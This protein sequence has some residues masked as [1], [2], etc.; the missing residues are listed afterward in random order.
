MICAVKKAGTFEGLLTLLLG[1]QHQHLFSSPVCI[2]YILEFRSCLTFI[3]HLQV[4]ISLNLNRVAEAE[5]LKEESLPYSCDLRFVFSV[6][7]LSS[8]DQ[9]AELFLPRLISLPF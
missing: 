6:L 5:Q 1:Q 8:R 2:N 4:L 3:F 9:I 7:S